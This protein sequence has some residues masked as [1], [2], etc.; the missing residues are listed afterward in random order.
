MPLKKNGNRYWKHPNVGRFV[1]KPNGDNYC[2]TEWVWTEPK[3]RAAELLAK[4]YS[5][6]YIADELGVHRNTIY[7]WQKVPEFCEYVDSIVLETGLALKKTRIA[8]LKRMAGSLETVFDKKVEELLKNCTWERLKD[9]SAEYREM[10]K[11]IATEK[12]EY[13]EVTKHEHAGSID[14]NHSGSIEKVEKHLLELD[15]SGREALEKEFA[16]VADTVIASL[17]HGTPVDIDTEKDAE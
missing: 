5:Q 8:K 1:P 16:K 2:R 12:E 17:T 6:R 10:L 9:I 13:I 7:N 4:G 14:V 11:Q 3:Y 15:D